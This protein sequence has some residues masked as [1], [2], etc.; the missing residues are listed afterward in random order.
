[1]KPD[2]LISGLPG[3]SLVRQG[4]ADLRAG[5]KT[6]PAYLI[7]IARPRLSRAGLLSDIHIEPSL[8]A[9]LCLYRLLRAEGGD[10]YSR[11]NA[12]VRE[13]VSFEQ[14]LDRRLRQASE[15]Q[16][17]TD[18]GQKLKAIL[19]KGRAERKPL[20]SDEEVARELKDRRGRLH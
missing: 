11:Y 7:V 20:L 18:R 6:A 13:L 3:E 17:T 4:L 16:P 19:D 12:L 5:R 1:M 2:E 8:E 14:A 9:E 15:W 10:A